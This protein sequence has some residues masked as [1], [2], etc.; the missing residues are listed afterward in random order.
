MITWGLFVNNWGLT[1]DTKKGGRL[2]LGLFGGLL[3]DKFQRS[4]L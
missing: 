3:N 4:W 2:G 1:V